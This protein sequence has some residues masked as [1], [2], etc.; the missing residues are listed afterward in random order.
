MY[1]S[2]A[3]YR[4]QLRKSG[5][6]H[7]ILVELIK[8]NGVIGTS[9]PWDPELFFNVR[10]VDGSMRCNTSNRYRRTLTMEMAGG[11]DV[12]TY[13]EMMGSES[14]SEVKA[15]R[16]VFLTAMPAS[17]APQ[18]SYIAVEGGVIEYYPLGVFHPS[19][20]DLETD[21]G[22]T[23]INYEGAD[24]SQYLDKEFGEV[25]TIA[26]NTTY[27]EA[28]LDIVSNFLVCP[29][30]YS[31]WIDTDASTWGL[32]PR[33]VYANSDNIWDALVDLAKAINKEPIWDPHGVFAF[34]SLPDFNTSP[35]E[36]VFL[37]TDTNGIMDRKAQL[38]EDPL[39]VVNAID[40][41]GNAPWLLF[42]VRGSASIDNPDLLWSTFHLGRRVK[43]IENAQVTATVQAEAIAQSEL[44]K[45]AGVP[46][47]LNMAT[48]PDPRFETNDIVTLANA[49]LAVTEDK[50]I[51]DEFVVP[52]T[53]DKLMTWKC[54]RI[55][56]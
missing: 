34:R 38:E 26:A 13:R 39:N 16:G 9:D 52:L 51:V 28:A 46:E 35:V 49:A 29:N 25:Y 19:G 21:N 24:R 14:F 36:D 27:W 20:F 6:K 23:T 40:V 18:A 55:R 53:F 5:S 54:R 12:L 17:P 42:P 10:V 41:V 48:I 31:T 3:E 32:T 7:H 4:T 45:Y 22:I 15:W 56:Q 47:N 44:L 33:L 1:Q 8:N 2:S 11:D 43:T 30:S 50:Y 37:D